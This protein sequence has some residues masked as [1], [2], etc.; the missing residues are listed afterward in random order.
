MSL[1]NYIVN[2]WL[3][4]KEAKIY[5]I[6]L[7]NWQLS[8]STIAR[9]SGESRTNL[10]SILENLVLK[11]FV[12]KSF[13][14]KVQYFEAISPDIILE[15]EKKKLNEFEKVIPDL[16]NLAKNNSLLKPQIK[17]YS[18]LE[19]LKLMYLKHLDMKKKFLYS[20]LSKQAIPA[21][22][23]EFLE[24][25]Y[26]PLRK[27]KGIFAKVIAPLNDENKQYKQQDVYFL[28]ETKLI[29]SKYFDFQTEILMWDGRYVSFVL[30]W[31]NND[32]LWLEV[33]SEN[34]YKSMKWIFDFL[35]NL[36]KIR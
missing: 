25:E 3:S 33:V 5:L 2:F 17:L 26:L 16:K 30:F 18:W 19:Q 13:V 28:R 9:L 22:F 24:N 4:E 32:M 31:E 8:V 1:E 15:K 6:L 12:N 27:Q 34:I 36:D 11:W 10:Y 20:F 7:E 21:K 29:N 35:W 14:W 23:L